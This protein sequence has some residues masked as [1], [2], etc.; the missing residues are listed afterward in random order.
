MPRRRPA[1]GEHITQ[2]GGD[3]NIYPEAPKIEI[4][5]IRPRREGAISSAQEKQV[6]DWIEAL[7]ENT[8]GITRSQDSECGREDSR[9]VSNWPKWK[10]CS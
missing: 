2:I 5:E 8:T 9:T 4:K 10:I 7:V 3:Q 1:I 6:K